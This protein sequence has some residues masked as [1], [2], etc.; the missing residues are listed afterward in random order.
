[1]GQDQN[2]T[3]P[4]SASTGPGVQY[5]GIAADVSADLWVNNPVLHE[6]IHEQITNTVLR[7]IFE[8]NYEPLG[9][10]MIRE[11]VWFYYEEIPGE[12]DE[13]RIVECAQDE[14]DFGRIFAEALS[15]PR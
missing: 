10:V 1:M 11:P 13:V 4:Q 15:A 8:N 9:E 14:A 2:P 5:I 6:Q 3:G 7:R 12:P